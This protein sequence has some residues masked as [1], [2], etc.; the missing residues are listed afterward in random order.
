LNR[1]K[2][3]RQQQ[4]ISQIKLAQMLKISAN[5]LNKIESGERHLS[6]SLASRIAEELNCN[7]NDI[8][9]K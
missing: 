4:G 9:L 1:V 5:H 2:E 8:F 7:T 6:Y 3:L